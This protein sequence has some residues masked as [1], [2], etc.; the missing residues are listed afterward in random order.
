MASKRST[1]TPAWLGAETWIEEILE[2]I[3]SAAGILRRHGIVC[4]ACG[5]PVWG[6]LAE[7]AR[8]AGI[9]N[10]KPVLDDLARGLAGSAQGQAS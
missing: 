10:L 7:N 9:E 4:L 3:P 8:R 2:K 6:S 5:Q 1:T